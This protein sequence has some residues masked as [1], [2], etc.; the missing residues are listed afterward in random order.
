MVEQK[1]CDDLVDFIVKLEKSFEK[2]D[3]FRGYRVHI[4]ALLCFHQFNGTRNDIANSFKKI[5][6]TLE[7]ED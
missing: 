6:E 5:I 7:K 4:F 1:V 3:Y 2:R